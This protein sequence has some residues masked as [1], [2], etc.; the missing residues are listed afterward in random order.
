MDNKQG[1]CET[2]VEDAA[3]Q[4]QVSQTNNLQ[5]ETVVMPEQVDKKNIDVDDLPADDL[6]GK[7]QVN[8]SGVA[9]DVNTSSEKH[10]TKVNGHSNG[11]V[12]GVS[13][14]DSEAELDGS[15]SENE[16]KETG[17]NQLADI[18]D[19]NTVSAETDEKLQSTISVA[20]NRVTET[21]TTES[22][23]L[24][25][26]GPTTDADAYDIDLDKSVPEL[27]TEFELLSQVGAT[28]VSHTFMHTEC[29]SISSTTSS[30]STR[31]S[32]IPVAVDKKKSSMI[33]RQDTYT[34]E[35]NCSESDN[36]TSVQKT[37]ADNN[38]DFAF[39]DE[40]DTS[41]GTALQRQNTYTV[42][43][44]KISESYITS[45]EIRSISS[46][47]VKSAS[48]KILD[49]EIMTSLISKDELDEMIADENLAKQEKEMNNSSKPAV[50]IQ[51]DKEVA[52]PSLMTADS[53]EKKIPVV[54]EVFTEKIVARLGSNEFEESM[55]KFDETEVN[56]HRLGTQSLESGTIEEEENQEIITDDQANSK[57]TY[58]E[59]KESD[60]ENNSSTMKEQSLQQ[61][62]IQRTEFEKENAS[63][64]DEPLYKDPEDSLLKDTN[65]LVQKELPT[66]KIE[67]QY[68]TAEEVRIQKHKVNAKEEAQ[69][70]DVATIQPT[71][72][73]ESTDP[74]KEPTI[75][76]ATSLLSSFIPTVTQMVST[77]VLSSEV[78]ENSEEGEKQSEEENI[79]TSKDV[80]QLLRDIRD[81]NLDCSLEDIE[82][83]IEGKEPV[84]HKEDLNRVSPE[85]ATAVN[86]IDQN[87]D[88]G[89][90]PEDPAV[91]G[92]EDWECSNLNTS[93]ESVE[94]RSSKLKSVFKR[95]RSRSEE[96][97]SLLD[98]RSNTNDHEEEE[99][100]DKVSVGCI[101]S[102]LLY[103]FIK[104]FD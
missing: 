98:D 28:D 97:K 17:L 24:E 19:E 87:P 93:L 75:L 1:L 68:V 51:F 26:M 58:T 69:L 54:E 96:R 71:I 39:E 82:A 27:V 42:R 85:F 11:D 52:T 3:V 15:D 44:S 60:K 43:S 5:E 77:P 32:R 22:H 61:E 92:I 102:W 12:N 91:K 72:A 8:S 103:I 16:D 100:D 80:E 99:E 63:Q 90:D 2:Q 70:M 95:R 40:V 83:M 25:T 86:L 35:T 76:E 89:F 9:V 37:D 66:A 101:N 56:I 33:T 4:R 88:K 47:E 67:D 55:A 23:S 20:S 78:E 13:G 7:V 74:T 18:P 34:I 81:P 62:E 31:T 65:S 79:R 50:E 73:I 84:T 94:S 104:I 14:S 36:S 10:E 41:M 21:Y 46:K 64:E 48:Q 29:S 38:E 57:V 49:G 6:V 59:Y 30:T 53:Q 45:Q